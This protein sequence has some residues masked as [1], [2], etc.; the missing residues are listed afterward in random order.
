MVENLQAA[1]FRNRDGSIALLVMNESEQAQPFWV[2]MDGQAAKTE[3]PAH[4]I[5]TLVF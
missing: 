1:A 3:S 2:W 4:S 5:M